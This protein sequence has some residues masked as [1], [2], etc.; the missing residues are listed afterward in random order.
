MGFVC[1]LVEM[2]WR[3]NAKGAAYCSDYAVPESD[4]NPNFLVCFVISLVVFDPLLG[5][6]IGE[7]YNAI[8][9]HSMGMD[10]VVK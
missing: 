3:L 6:R 8:V 9:L 1:V 10:F 4:K 7:I 2:F 5:R